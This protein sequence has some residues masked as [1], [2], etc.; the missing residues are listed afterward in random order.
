MIEELTGRCK[1]NPSRTASD[2]R[3]LIFE[4]VPTSFLQHGLRH[5]TADCTVCVAMRYRY[6]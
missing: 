2:Q 3:T 1:A 4:P 6:T 5:S